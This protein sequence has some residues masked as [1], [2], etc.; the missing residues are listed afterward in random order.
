MKR[1]HDIY[2]P[3]EERKKDWHEV[4]RLHHRRSIVDLAKSNKLVSFETGQRLSE[5]GK[6][7]EICLFD[8]EFSTAVD[9]EDTKNVL[10]NVS[11]PDVH[12]ADVI[13]AEDAKKE[14]TYFVNYLRNPKKF[15]GTGI[16]AS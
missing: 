13:G 4:E 12:F 8:F 6:E 9:A 15:A 10:S 7:A 1:I 3:E 5:D 11:R 16:S 2:R 14:L